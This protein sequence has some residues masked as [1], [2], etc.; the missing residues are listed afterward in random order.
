MAYGVAIGHCEDA[1]PNEIYNIRR[2]TGLNICFVYNYA[3]AKWKNALK[4]PIKSWVTPPDPQH[5][6]TQAK[7]LAHF[8]YCA[9]FGENK[10]KVIKLKPLQVNLLADLAA[11][12]ISNQAAVDAILSA[13][14]KGV[15]PRPESTR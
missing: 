6:G 9:T 7:D 10:T 5:P 1:K 2:Y 12:S 8:P 3:G 13:F 14:D 11:W 15:L 4:D